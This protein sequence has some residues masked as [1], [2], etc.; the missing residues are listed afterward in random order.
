MMWRKDNSQ[1]KK[2]ALFFSTLGASLLLAGGVFAAYTLVDEAGKTGIRITPGEVTEDPVGTVTLEWGSKTSFTLVEG[3]S[4]GEP[5]E[6]SI[7]VV[8]NDDDGPLAY[9]GVLDVE[10]QDLTNKASGPKL[11]DYLHVDV[12]KDEITTVE[13]ENHFIGDLGRVTR[14]AAK[15]VETS[16]SYNV[17]TD[18]T[19]GKRTVCF[20]IS[21]DSDATP[22]VNQISTDQ[23][24]LSV[25]WNR[26]SDGTNAVTRVYIPSNGWSTMYVYSYDDSGKQNDE[27][28][29]VQL[30]KDT[31]TGYFVADLL[32]SHNHFIFTE[33]IDS[34]DHRWPADGEGGMSR[35]SLNIHE[36]YYFNWSTKAF[37]ETPPAVEYAYYLVGEATDS[38]S[39]LAANGFVVE[40]TELPGD[41]IHQ[42]K[43]T[44]TVEAGKSYKI[45]GAADVDTPWFG[46]SSVEDGQTSFVDA[47][48][49]DNFEFA[50]AGTYDVY[51]KQLKDNTS[52]Y[53]I[54]AVAK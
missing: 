18:G 28:P 27:W 50:A 1:M 13:D 39:K 49:N 25:D 10:L 32:N 41:A 16:A 47:N 12:Y 33:A 20:K 31:E 35:T 22:Y 44:V 45:R 30:A 24:Y 14:A 15:T 36:G 21:I 19:T 51:L 26:K 46:Y 8:A 5:E 38:W 4:I 43:A 9:A 40:E 54:V 6:R 53:K 3:L 42:W 52:Y 34:T 2:K 23:V 48:D 29:G 7:E 37:T 17:T 11:I